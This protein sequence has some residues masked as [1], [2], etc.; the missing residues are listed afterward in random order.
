LFLQ[1][2]WVD[3]LVTP[4]TT[5]LAIQIII[6]QICYTAQTKHIHQQWAW[7]TLDKKAWI[8]ILRNEKLKTRQVPTIS[9]HTL[10]E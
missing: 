3:E 5:V 6:Y 2:R 1:K 7:A 4:I 9:L 8:R 10:D